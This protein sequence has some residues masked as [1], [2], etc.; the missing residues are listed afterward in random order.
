MLVVVSPNRLRSKV[1]KKS[2]NP[3]RIRPFGDQISDQNQLVARFP[4]RLVQ[5]VLELLSATVDVSH[6]EGA[7]GH[8][9]ILGASGK[10]S[11]FVRPR[12]R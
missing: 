5:Q 8:I 2:N 6:D 10:D 7:A 11:K 3:E 1:P 9:S 12:T 4:P